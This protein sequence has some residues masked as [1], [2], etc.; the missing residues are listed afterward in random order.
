MC[1]VTYIPLGGDSFIFSSNR[2]ESPAR[3]P[4]NLTTDHSRGYPLVFPRDT[5]AGGT[6]IAVNPGG[7]LVCIL[8]GAFEK[9]QHRPPYKRS[10]GLMALDFFDYPSAES[11]ALEYGFDGM[12]PFTLVTWDNGKLWEIRWDEATL[13]SR[14]LD[15]TQHHIWSS[16]TLYPGPVRAKREGWF[17]AWLEGRTDFSLEAIHQLHRNGGEGDPHNDFVMNRQIVRTVSITHILR[18]PEKVE[19]IYHDLLREQVRVA[20]DLGFVV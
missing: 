6:W 4:Q 1:T 20:S 16:A 7:R 3:S 9:H 13:H 5:A 8:N 12:E 14:Q 10:R 15:Q 19:M 17:R 11:F 2:D 18:A